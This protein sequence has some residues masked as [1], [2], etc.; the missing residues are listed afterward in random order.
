M[1]RPFGFEIANVSTHSHPKVAG[2]IHLSLSLRPRV[3][4]H[5]HP[6]VAGITST[7]FALSFQKFQHTATRRWLG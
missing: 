3:S 2:S 4:T 7:R 1:K 6:K 5:S